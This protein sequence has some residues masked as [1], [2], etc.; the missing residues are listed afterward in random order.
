MGA[1]YT[2]TV[3]RPSGGTIKS[4]GVYCGGRGSSCS[5]SMPAPMLLGLEATP[6]KGYVFSGWTG[7]CSGTSRGYFLALDGPRT[8]G[9]A[10]TAGN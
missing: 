7:H 1:P 8:C 9:A 6:D 2:L 5:V 3:D 10:F 4:A